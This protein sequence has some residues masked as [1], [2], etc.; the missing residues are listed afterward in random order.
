LAHV[1]RTL[2]GARFQVGK[3]SPQSEGVKLIDR[4]SAYATLSAP[5]AADQ[6]FPAPPRHIG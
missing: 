6:P 1:G 5:R 2:W 4:K 3:P